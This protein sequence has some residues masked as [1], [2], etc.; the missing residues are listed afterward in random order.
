VRIYDDVEV[1][2]ESDEAIYF[3]FRAE[4]DTLRYNF[5]RWFTANE[6]TEATLEMSV[7]G[8]EVDEAGIRKL[9]D[10]F[11]ERATPIEESRL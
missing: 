3:K 10:E 2:E 11:A 4:N 7:A 5:F 8:R 6:D 1:L 9:F